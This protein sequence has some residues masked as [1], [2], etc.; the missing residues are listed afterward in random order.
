MEMF[1]IMKGVDN[2]DAV[3]FFIR[4]DSVRWDQGLQVEVKED[5]SYF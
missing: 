5:E 1:K 4:M 3:V 2:I